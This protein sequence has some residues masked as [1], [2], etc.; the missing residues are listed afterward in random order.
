MNEELQLRI[1]YWSWIISFNELQEKG[2]HVSEDVINDFL[3]WI[4]ENEEKLR[5]YNIFNT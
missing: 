2:I 3:N 4:N 5:F 1:K